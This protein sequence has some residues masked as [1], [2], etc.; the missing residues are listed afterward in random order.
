MKKFKELNLE[1]IKQA[2]SQS[3]TLAGVLH[4][5]EC[6]DNTSNRDSLKKTIQDNDIDVSHL[7]TKTSKKLYLENPKYC[8]HCGKE[9]SYEKRENDFCN[10]SCATS[11]NN[12]GVCKHGQKK[13]EH[14]YC[15]NCGK[16]I[17]SGRHFCDNTCYAEYERKQYIERWKRG[18]ETGIIGEDG[19]ATAVRKYMFEKHNNACQKCGWNQVNPFTGLVPL[20]IHHIDGDC[21]NNQENNLELLCPNCHALTENFGS[22]N[23]NCTRID[24]RY[25]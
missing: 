2:I 25:R 4:L 20:Q 7:K 24:K 6:H 19:I 3:E 15:L 9:I 14:S 23:D 12:K 5:L 1:E 16:E 17:T 8:K 13:P 22:R 18:E 21:K 11:F 10:S